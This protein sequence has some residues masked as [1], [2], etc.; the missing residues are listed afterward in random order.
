[1][2]FIAISEDYS[3]FINQEKKPVIAIDMD[4]LLIARK[5]LEAVKA[6]KSA[7]S[8][9]FKMTGLG[10]VAH[11]LEVKVIQEN[12]SR[13][14][15]IKLTQRTYAEKLLRTFGMADCTP[16]STPMDEN[17]VLEPSKEL[18]DS[19]DP[20]KVS[21]SGQQLQVSDTLHS[22]RYCICRQPIEP[23][24]SEP[25]RETLCSPKKAFSVP[26]GYQ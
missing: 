13:G 11:Y 25:I 17:L 6:I 9:H 26:E 21:A 4:D 19:D 16:V 1:M 18:A 10:P 7:L 8:E 14:N 20:E 2:V 12:T 23:L 15:K 3:I 22:S 24:R 5:D